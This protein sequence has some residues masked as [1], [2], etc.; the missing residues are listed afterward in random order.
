[1]RYLSVNKHTNLLSES[2]LLLTFKSKH[3]FLFYNAFYRYRSLSN[4]FYIAVRCPYSWQAVDN[5]CVYFLPGFEG[6]WSDV[7]YFCNSQGGSVLTIDTQGENDFITDK[8][9]AS[10]L[11]GMLLGCRDQRDE[12]YWRCHNRVYPY[13]VHWTKDTQAGFWGMSLWNISVFP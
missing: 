13:M 9:V 8:L 3:I 5:K 2:T 4:I 11:N 7:R 12:G 1:M 10:G 6:I